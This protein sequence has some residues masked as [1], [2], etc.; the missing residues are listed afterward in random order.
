MSPQERTEYAES[1]RAEGD[2]RPAS[3][4]EGEAL[5]MEDEARQQEQ[6]ADEHEAEARRL[7]EHVGDTKPGVPQDDASDRGDE[8]KLDPSARD[9]R[10]KGKADAAAGRDDSSAGQAHKAHP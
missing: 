6:A 10:T 9:D 7:R 3:Q 2:T 5:G 1:L 8:P 4:I